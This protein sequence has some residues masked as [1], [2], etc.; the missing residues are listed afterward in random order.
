M[1]P[2]DAAFGGGGGVDGS[3]SG[4]AEGE[5]G[6]GVNRSD[7][8]VPA[9]GEADGG[10]EPVLGGDLGERGGEGGEGGEEAA[11]RTETASFM[12]PGQ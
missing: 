5:A 10:G 3:E 11:A 2:L 9:G 6:G 12:P 7:S 4:V 1:S 8:G